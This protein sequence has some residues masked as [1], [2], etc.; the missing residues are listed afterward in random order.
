MIICTLTESLAKQHDLD[1]DTY[2]TS[3]AERLKGGHERSL[4]LETACM[5][6]LEHVNRQ[7]SM[8]VY[9][10]LYLDETMMFANFYRWDFYKQLHVSHSAALGAKPTESV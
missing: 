10:E 5:K 3:P 2:D 6:H 1:G 9:N 4:S 7:L 8:V